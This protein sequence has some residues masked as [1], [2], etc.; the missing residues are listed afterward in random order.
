M[1][2]PEEKKT[3][4]GITFAVVARMLGLFL[5]LP[6][7]SPY[8]SRMEGSTPILTG[9]AVGV[10]GLTQALFQIPFGYLS[11]RIG[12]KPVIVMGFLAYIVGSVLGGL[13]NTVWTM[14]LARLI[15]GAGAISSAAISLAADLI[16]EEVRSSAFAKIGASI[17]LTF[18][19]SIV[20][21][22]VLAGK[23]GV[24]FIFFL[25]AFLSS[26]AMIYLV[27]FIREPE[28]E[29]GVHRSPGT[30]LYPLLVRRDIV[31]I[32]L[33]VFILH[34][35]LVSVFTVVPV[36]LIE[37]Y[38]MPKP[39][40]WKVYLPVI[41]VSVLLMIPAVVYGEKRGKIGQVL[42][43]GVSLIAL[44]FLSHLVL[45]NFLGL[46]FMLALFFIGFHFLEPILPSLVTK[47]AGKEVRGLSVGVFNTSQFVGAFT[48]GLIGG[49][50]LKTG[51]TTM[52]I[53]NLAISVLWLTGITL[54][55]S[56]VRF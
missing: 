26:L 36:E 38:G 11:D 3:V 30:S 23:F 4:A 37:V 35:L 55:V 14:I 9:L 56:K 18:A 28:R 10:Y 19:L 7:L 50:F 13:A 44:G 53:I 15:Q 21:A 52:I 49:V 33:S 45:K 1:F 2:T 16:R 8:V 6:V 47:V 48:G 40:H 27:V 17:S 43:A 54:W 5:L 41:L 42:I 32:N 20:L 12:R 22:P 34:T 24:P 25:T 39:E 46:V 31:M 29:A 51:T